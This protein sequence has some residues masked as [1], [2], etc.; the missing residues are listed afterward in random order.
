MIILEDVISDT[1]KIKYIYHISDIH[2]RRYEKHNEFEYIFQKLYEY[3]EKVKNKNSIIVIT[4]DLLH[5]KDNLT[6]DC[7]MKTWNFLNELQKIM[8]LFLITGNHD[9]V[10][11][12]NHV[13]DS[14]EAILNDKNIEDKN[15]YYLRNSGAYR[16]GN[17]CFGVSSLIDKQ[18]TYA[19]DIVSDAEFKIGLYHGGVGKTETSVG[20]KL[21][22]DK[23]VSDFDGYDYV[24]LGDIHKFQYVADNMAYSSSL[25]SQ[26][27]GETD[28]YHGVLVWDLNKAKQTY[29]IIKNKYRYMEITVKDNKVYKDNKEI[30]YKEYEFPKNCRLRIN[31]DDDIFYEEVKKYLRKNY[32]KISLYE[33]G[34]VKMI[35]EDDNMNKEDISYLTLLEKYI[36]KLSDENKNKCREIF[37]Q[38]IVESEL[39]VEKSL[40]EWKL[41]DLEFSNLFSYGENNFIDFT[42]LQNNEITG[43]F[44]PNSYG[45]STIIDVLLLA[46]F[47][48]FSRNVYSKHRTIPSYVINYKYKDF[49]IKLRFIIGGYLYVIHKKG[50][51]V[52]KK[53]TKTGFKII[54]D[55]N[56]LF[57]Y[58]DGIETDLTGKDRFETLSILK[59]IIG[60]YDEFCL[61]TLYLQNNEKNFYDMKPQDRK[62]FLYNLLHLHKFEYMTKKFKSKSKE[63]KILLNNILSQLNDEDNIEELKDKNKDYENEILLYENDNLKIKKKLNNIR[64][65]K[66]KILT[67]IDNSLLDIECKYSGDINLLKNKSN[68]IKSL[69]PQEVYYE[70]DLNDFKNIILE[71]IYIFESKLVNIDGE[72]IEDTLLN[73]ENDLYKINNL[74]KNKKD[75]ESKYNIYLTNKSKYEK[76]KF[77]LNLINKNIESNEI[78]KKCK[79]CM[80]RKCILD[81]LVNE[82]D[83]TQNQLSEIKII[84]EDYLN[85]NNLK[86]SEDIKF[87]ILNGINFIKNKYYNNEIKL[88]KIIIEQINYLQSIKTPDNDFLLDT[89]NNYN[90]SIRYNENKNN[91]EE[92]K[93]LKLIIDELNNKLI[94]NNNKIIE[95]KII[96]N[97]NNFTINSYN[98]NMKLKSDYKNQINIYD[99]LAKSVCIHGIPS[100]IL[101]KYLTGIQ[102]Y[103]NNL[104]S[105]FINKTV[106]LILDGNYLYINIYNDNNDIINILGGMEHFIVNISLK[107]T[108]SKLSVLPKCGLLI[109]DEGVSVLDKEHIEKFHIIAKFLKTNYKNV[110]I[111][112]HIDGIKDFIAHFITI[113]KHS[114]NDSHIY[115]H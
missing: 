75:I 45:K 88:L 14:I 8:P 105:P 76:L 92:I 30:N 26:N 98:K 13:K 59:N 56:K 96:I 18:V 46:L 93:K 27:F 20:F 7:V 28:D 39:S 53:D 102:N 64:N 17:V 107:I 44:A 70:Y 80:K 72:Y 73:L 10:E 66:D 63:N 69:I 35:F 68:I 50:H 32:K 101:N 97:N 106:E 99:T 12:N 24:L 58:E 6:P 113:N 71:R 42:K 74:L 4:G 109:I 83:V 48:D 87:K 21:N 33:S 19:K 78:N 89:F 110:I 103:M 77:Q 38:N 31:I 114:N 1:P 57:R 104:I 16:Y 11:T 61:T 65:N 9:F 90:E 86:S 95:Y 85:Y 91:I 37:S 112:S 100:I 79:V 36:T 60:N 52:K 40:L 67:G 54:F 29:H 2:I 55:I 43:L 82:R 111:I 94:Q 108:L 25:I 49:E 84:E 22:G 15:I 62:N 34:I 41:L 51:K 47:E 81:N 23:L 5:N 115:F 3:F